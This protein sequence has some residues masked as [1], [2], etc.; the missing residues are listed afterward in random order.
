M[1][2][3]FFPKPNGTWVWWLITEKPPFVKAICPREF[4]TKQQVVTDIR[5]IQKAMGAAD[6]QEGVYRA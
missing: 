4:P 2:F 3:T 6:I 1:T 5:R